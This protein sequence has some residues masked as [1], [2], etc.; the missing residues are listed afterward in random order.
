MFKYFNPH[1]NGKGVRMQGSSRTPR[2]VGGDHD[3]ES[4]NTEAENDGKVRERKISLTDQGKAAKLLRQRLALAL[5]T[6]TKVKS[7]SSNSESDPEITGKDLKARRE[8]KTVII[9]Q[10]NSQ[11]PQETMI[12]PPREPQMT[13][14]DGIPQNGVKNQNYSAT[15][16]SLKSGVPFENNAQVKT[17][18]ANLPLPSRKGREGISSRFASSTSKK[19]VSEAVINKRQSRVPPNI[20][21]NVTKNSEDSSF[22]AH[23]SFDVLSVIE[24]ELI[25]L[26]ADMHETTEDFQEM[27]ASTLKLKNKLEELR[28]LRTNFVM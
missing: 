25:Q 23:N 13:D 18:M 12:K 26:K 20:N 9:P 4:S 14:G 24:G 10:K 6:N 1:A 21:G 7:D 15:N 16:F 28:E 22:P 3:S 19:Y 27:N 11:G 17:L 2:R 5:A 8:R